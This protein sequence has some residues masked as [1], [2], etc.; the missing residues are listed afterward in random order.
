MGAARLS[1]A[2]CQAD[3]RPAPSPAQLLL[4]Y[5]F[6]LHPNPAD[7]FIVALGAAGGGLAQGARARALALRRLQPRCELSLQARG[8]LS[9]APP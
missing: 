4:T 5:G 1:S 3:A 7:R 6:C 9:A 2:R 8:A